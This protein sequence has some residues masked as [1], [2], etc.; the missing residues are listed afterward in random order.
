M[1]FPS[2]LDLLVGVLAVWRASALVTYERGPFAVFQRIR[3]IAG[4]PHFDDGTP[5]DENLDG[6]LARLMAC[7]WCFSPYLG[8]V[9]LGLWFVHR[10]ATMFV[11]YVLALSA[12]AVIAERIIRG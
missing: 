7:V 5:D 11:S 9:W 1:Q 8:L 6:E 12:G 4:V 2:L 10:D 3:E